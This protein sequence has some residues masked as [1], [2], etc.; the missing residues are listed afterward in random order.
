MTNSMKAMLD[1]LWTTCYSVAFGWDSTHGDYEKRQLVPLPRIGRSYTE[2]KRQGLIPSP[3]VG[4]S[5]MSSYNGIETDC[6]L[7]PELCNELM[8]RDPHEVHEAI[9]VLRIGRLSGRRKK[10]FTEDYSNDMNADDFELTK[11]LRSNPWDFDVNPNFF[12]RNVRQ[13]IPAPRVGRSANTHTNEM[14]LISGYN[15][16]DDDDVDPIDL[17]LRA[18]FIPRLGKRTTHKSLD[19]S[20]DSDDI[21]K[22]AAAF[23]PRIGRAAFTP[24]IGKKASFVPRIGRSSA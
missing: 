9:P 15:T 21:Y 22:R 20:I 4:R 2:E 17:Q 24:R 10:S 1:F 13:L 23:T 3:R 16:V 11:T 6:S 7:T 19:Q 18:A 12:E 14:R 5:S 8:D